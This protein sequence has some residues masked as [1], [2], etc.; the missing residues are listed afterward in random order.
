MDEIILSEAQ[1]A[2]LAM[3][4]SA[5]LRKWRVRGRGPVYLKLG[6]KVR[7]R[8]VDIESWILASRVEPGSKKRRK[9]ARA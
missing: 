1:A 7:Y 2:K 6:G 4:K 5:T 3:Q 8:K 9:A